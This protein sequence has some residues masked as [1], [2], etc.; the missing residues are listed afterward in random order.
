M[1]F[2]YVNLENGDLLNVCE[3]ETELIECLRYVYGDT[4]IIFFDEIQNFPN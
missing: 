4:K 3:S 1:D 2:I